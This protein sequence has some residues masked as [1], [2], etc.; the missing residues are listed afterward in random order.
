MLAQQ[1]TEQARMAAL[2]QQ[3]TT[4]ASAEAP[5]DPVSF[6]ASLPSSLRQ[7]VLA[8]MDDTTVAVLPP[9]LAAE[10]QALRRELEERHRRLM[11]ERLFAQAAGAGSLSAILRHSGACWFLFIRAFALLLVTVNVLYLAC[12]KIY[13]VFLTLLIYDINW[14]LKPLNTWDSL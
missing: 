8:D 1:R 4:P 10:A 7:Q 13:I 2:Q 5:V 6:L 14:H 12:M 11:Q 9:D 3:Q